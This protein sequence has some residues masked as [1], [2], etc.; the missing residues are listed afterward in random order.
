[1]GNLMA[2]YDCPCKKCQIVYKN[3]KVLKDRKDLV[4]QYFT[5]DCLVRLAVAT[6]DRFKKSADMMSDDNMSDDD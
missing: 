6:D 1:M 2:N 5:R 4:T 3:L